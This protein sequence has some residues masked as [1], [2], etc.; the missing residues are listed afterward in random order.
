MNLIFNNNTYLNKFRT[1]SG[2]TEI[3]E[4]ISDQ[5]IFEDNSN[6][7]HPYGR[8][9]SVLSFGLRGKFIINNTALDEI[10]LHP[11]VKD[12]KIVAVSII[13][14]FRKGKSFLMDYGLRYMYGNVSSQK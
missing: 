2:S 4:E 13:G 6:Q 1:S 9:V 14:A 8:P 10:F 12:R 7:I 3:S 5:E 11:E